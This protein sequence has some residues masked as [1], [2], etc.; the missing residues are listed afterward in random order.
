MAEFSK[1]SEARK[2]SRALIANDHCSHIINSHGW[3]LLSIDFVNCDGHNT[4]SSCNLMG[5]L[6]TAL[7][8]T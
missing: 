3:L 5:C 8:F 6:L 1:C 7:S 2:I 4:F